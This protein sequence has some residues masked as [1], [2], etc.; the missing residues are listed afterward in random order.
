[1]EVAATR[2]SRAGSPVS[3]SGPCSAP[4]VFLDPALFDRFGLATTRQA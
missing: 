4:E 1:M 2:T 3:P